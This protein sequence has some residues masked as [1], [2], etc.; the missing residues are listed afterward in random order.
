MNNTTTATE[1]ASPLSIIIIGAGIGGLTLANLL[2]QTHPTSS[3]RLF[4]R[5]SAAYARTQGGTLGLKEPGGL[6]ALRQLE[7]EGCCHRIWWIIPVASANPVLADFFSS[8]G[9]PERPSHSGVRLHSSDSAGPF[10]TL[11]MTGSYNRI[12]LRLLS[13]GNRYQRVREYLTRR[14]L[15]MGSADCHGWGLLPIT[16]R[17]TVAF[18]FSRLHEPH[19]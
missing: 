10:T 9:S 7:M 2:H 4:E 8:L 3:V 6:D 14:P 18:S 5:D 16:L 15:S 13:S 12:W 1:R 11:P 19:L 17:Q